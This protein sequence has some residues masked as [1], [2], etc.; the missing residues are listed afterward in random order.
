MP[1]NPFIKAL[2][3][4]CV[5]KHTAIALLLAEAGADVSFSTTRGSDAL[6]AAQAIRRSY[7]YDL[8][9]AQFHCGFISHE[10]EFD[11][12]E[13]SLKR[14]ISAPAGMR[15]RLTSGRNS[16]TGEPVHKEEKSA[17][18]TLSARIRSIFVVRDWIDLGGMAIGIDEEDQVRIIIIVMTAWRNEGEGER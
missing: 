3:R 17:F 16:V 8:K 11:Q 5:G 14:H 15:D 4:A 7:G 18:S 1:L 9:G 10:F 6:K 12:S 2:Y 13:V